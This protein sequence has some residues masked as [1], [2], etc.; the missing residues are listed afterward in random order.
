M[1]LLTFQTKKAV[2]KRRNK[3]ETRKRK[4]AA[5]LAAVVFKTK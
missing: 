1:F 5:K 2:K 4:I 3:A